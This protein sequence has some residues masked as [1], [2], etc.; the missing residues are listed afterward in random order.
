MIDWLFS[1]ER[2]IAHAFERAE[3]LM[4]YDQDADVVISIARPD[5]TV[6]ERHTVEAANVQSLRAG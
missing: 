2:A 5:G 3:E 6:Q 1:K 4:R